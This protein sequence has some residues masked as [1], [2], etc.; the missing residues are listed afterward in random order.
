MNCLLDKY[1]FNFLYIKKLPKVGSFYSRNKD[2]FSTPA[3]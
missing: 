3:G 1:A 2:Y